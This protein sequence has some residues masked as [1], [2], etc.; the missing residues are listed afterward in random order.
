MEI[1]V[2][3]PTFCEIC[4]SDENEDRILLCDGRFCSTINPHF[5]TIFSLLTGCDLGYHL[6]C[7]T[8][9]LEEVPEGNW[10]CAHCSPRVNDNIDYDEVIALMQ[11]A[12]E[13]LDVGRNGNGRRPS[14]R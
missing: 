5:H 14:R 9:P 13:V 12:N 2:E 11:E 1:I 4:H 3:D 7:L 10:F 6:Y 8:P